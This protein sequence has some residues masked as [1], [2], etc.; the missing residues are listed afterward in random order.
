METFLSHVAVPE[1]NPPP[2][3]PHPRL[4]MLAYGSTRS[5]PAAQITLAQH[6]PADAHLNQN[7]DARLA[8]IGLALA[9][10]QLNTQFRSKLLL[11]MSTA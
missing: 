4:W 11:V 10:P 9:R 8:S 1:V 3:C 2:L 6:W 7:L 5:S